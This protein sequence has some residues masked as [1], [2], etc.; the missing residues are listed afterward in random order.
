MVVVSNIDSDNFIKNENKSL[1]ILIADDDLAS[2]TLISKTIE[3]FSKVEFRVRT[4]QDAVDCCRSNPDI[5]LILMD[6]KMPVMDG[7]EATRQIR[8]FNKKVIIIA[9]TAFALLGDKE[10]ALVAGC[11]D[12]ISKPVDSKLLIGILQKYFNKES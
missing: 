3:S 11:N 1:K 5:D 7:Y 4:G 12:Y 9:Q 8:L 2:E 10:K 6:I